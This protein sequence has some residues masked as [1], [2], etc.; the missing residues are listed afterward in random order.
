[1]LMIALRI[2]IQLQHIETM[3]QIMAHLTDKEKNVIK[4]KKDA[5]FNTNF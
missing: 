3:L 4:L 1:M 5:L 2:R